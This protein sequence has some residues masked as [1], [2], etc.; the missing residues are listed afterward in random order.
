MPEYKTNL[1]EQQYR[2]NFGRAVSFSNKIRSKY[3]K[4][5]IT[6]E[7]FRDKIFRYSKK[8]NLLVIRD[9]EGKEII[10]HPENIFGYKDEEELK[11]KRISE[12]IILKSDWAKDPDVKFPK[13][14]VTV[15]ERD[16]PCE[17][18]YKSNVKNIMTGT[19]DYA[20]KV[21]REAS[22]TLCETPSGIKVSSPSF[23]SKGA[24]SRRSERTVNKCKY[25]FGENSKQV[26][27]FHTHPGI[28]NEAF[29]IQDMISS[30]D[31][32]FNY[33]NSRCVVSKIR[34]K[35]KR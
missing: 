8:L 22:Y 25:E 30:F 19:V 7:E 34:K 24:V 21:G 29:S 32:P 23:G 13:R 28:G 17:I 35:R 18:V 10:I 11:E 15:G 16:S 33:N 27:D 31:D 3:E 9:D 6:A 14:F 20:D 2:S 4:G 5:E 1:T 12:D 26:G